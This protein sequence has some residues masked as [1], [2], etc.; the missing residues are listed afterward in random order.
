MNKLKVKMLKIYQPVSEL[1]WMNYK[2][3]KNKLTYHHIKKK[4]N[5]G[6][7]IIEN[8]ALLMPVAHEYLHLIEAK[9]LSTYIALNKLFKHINK[10]RYEPTSEQRDVIEYLLRMF[11]L[12]YKPE[13]TKLEEKYLK[14]E[15]KNNL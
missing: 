4:S 15:W 3:E 1:D 8:G 14:R 2:L 5:G 9:D 11:E 13:K 12:L 10:Q 7:R 6:K